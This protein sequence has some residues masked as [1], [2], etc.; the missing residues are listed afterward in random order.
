MIAFEHDFCSAKMLDN[1]VWRA[2]GVGW[3]HDATS[4]KLGQL[5]QNAAKALSQTNFGRM[6]RLSD[7]RLEGA[8]QYGNCL[9]SMINQI[10][11]VDS[12]EAQELV[13]PIMLLLMSAAFYPYRPWEWFLAD[14]VKTEDEWSSLQSDR[15]AAMSHLRGIATIL[16]MTGPEAYQEPR[17]L[18]VFSCARTLLVSS[19]ATSS[20]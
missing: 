15:S 8:I 9:R 1:F 20:F 10:A 4:G 3:L 2:F 11:R 16:Q 6:E 13:V 5:P 17:L 12:S 7:L 14:Q 19:S 18:K